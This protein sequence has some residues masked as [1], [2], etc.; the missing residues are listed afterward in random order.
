MTCRSAVR[1]KI[2]LLQM[3]VLSRLIVFGPYGR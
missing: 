3:L 1:L 2:E